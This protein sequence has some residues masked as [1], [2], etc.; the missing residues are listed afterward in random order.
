[1]LIMFIFF[2]MWFGCRLLF[3]S[4][5]TFFSIAAPPVFDKCHGVR[6]NV[7]EQPQTAGVSGASAPSGP[8]DSSVR[9]AHRGPPLKNAPLPTLDQ[10]RIAVI[11]L[12]YVGLPL[13]V[14]FGRTFPTLGFDI[15]A[16]RIAE[17]REGRDNTLEVEPELLAQ[18]PVAP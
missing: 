11:G 12:G 4:C 16:A 6:R 7:D 2:P 5:Y 10:V 9:A 14:A 8:L 3:T 13:A 1:M 17:L 18:A 15:N